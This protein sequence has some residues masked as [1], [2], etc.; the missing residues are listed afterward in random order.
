M[1]NLP[2]STAFGSLPCRQLADVSGCVC[3]PHCTCPPALLLLL[4]L[5][6]P[7]QLASYLLVLLEHLAD[8]AADPASAYGSYDFLPHTLLFV[9]QRGQLGPSR[10]WERLTALH[11]L[12]MKM[13]QHGSRPPAS[14]VVGGA[15]GGSAGSG[16]RGRAGGAPLYRHLSCRPGGWGPAQDFGLVRGIFL[17]G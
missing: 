15:D 12:A 2:D 7:F 10:I 14:F 8:C 5:P 4:L 11:L 13:W 16:G 17:A 3:L 6:L 9:G 1:Y